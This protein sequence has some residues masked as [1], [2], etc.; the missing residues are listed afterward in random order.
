MA[1]RGP[2]VLNR[3][4]LIKYFFL[5][6]FTKVPHGEDVPR[7]LLEV[8]LD[9]LLSQPDMVYILQSGTFQALKEYVLQSVYVYILELVGKKGLNYWPYRDF[10][11]E[12]TWN[13]ALANLRGCSLSFSVGLL[14]GKMK[15][16]VDVGHTSALLKGVSDL[17]NKVSGYDVP[18]AMYYD[19]DYKKTPMW[20]VSFSVKRSFDSRS[21]IL[22]V[23]G[24]YVM[25]SKA[26]KSGVAC[27]FSTIEGFSYLFGNGAYDVMGEIESKVMQLNYDEWYTWLKIMPLQMATK[28][29]SH[30]YGYGE[31]KFDGVTEKQGKRVMRMTIV[32]HIRLAKDNKYSY[33]MC[34]GPHQLEEFF[35]SE[36][37]SD[38]GM[39]SDCAVFQ[40]L[41]SYY[42]VIVPN[43][44]NVM[45][46]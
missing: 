22:Y 44:S 23:S 30:K 43:E 36:M 17:F 42:G 35:L 32:P 28:Y 3:E 26:P 18:P 4:S 1:H 33:F 15:A 27:M 24:D 19:F 31:M 11:R 5:S 14:S 6:H 8:A 21:D 39:L 9:R 45:C 46:W 10:V 2:R 41:P 38:N 29:H 40:M 13:D 25:R 37:R 12:N 7:I 34:F 16:K 20:V